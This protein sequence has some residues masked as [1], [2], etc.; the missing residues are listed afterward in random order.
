MAVDV[1][2]GLQWGDEGKG[3]L[4][5]VLAPKYQIVARFQGGANAGH[6]LWL[7]GK[8]YVLHLVPSGIFQEDCYCLIGAGVVLDPITFR[9]EVLQLEAAGIPVRKRLMLA[10]RTHLILPGH[11]AIDAARELAQGSQKIGSTLR[12]ISP[13]YEDKTGRRGLRI[14]DISMADFK[15]H[16]RRLTETHNIYLALLNALHVADKQIDE[17]LDATQWIVE[18]ISII[19]AE[20]WLYDQINAGSSVLAEGAQGSLL[21]IDFGSYPYVTSSNTV[22][23]GSFTGLGIP[24]RFI[25]NVFGVFKAYCTRVGNGPFPTELHDQTGE[26]LRTLGNEFGATTGRPRRCGWLDIPA[27]RYA[28]RRN[29]VS[30]LLMTK[31]DILAELQTIQVATHYLADGQELSLPPY[32]ANAAIIPQYQTLPAWSKP[33]SINAPALQQYIQLIEK[34]V[35]TKIHFLSTGPERESWVEL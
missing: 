3:K 31:A 32:N 23:S 6:T 18:N 22:V 34:E 29:G 16:V 9:E 5:D 25:R 14:G 26:Q 24:P 7:Q 1:L 35:Q 2:V 4:I 8:K 28:I 27:L 21:D 20:D 30:H 11:R 12:G 33:T 19:D 13:A 17:F 15:T 10:K